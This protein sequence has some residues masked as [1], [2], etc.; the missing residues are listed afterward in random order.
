MLSSADDVNG[1]R[2]T[3]LRSDTWQLRSE[4]RS[5]IF[6]KP[7]SIAILYIILRNVRSKKGIY[8]GRGSIL[9]FFVC[10]LFFQKAT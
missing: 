6:Q 9:K 2:F 4:I 1:W 3:Q 7:L 5:L 8:R 10:T